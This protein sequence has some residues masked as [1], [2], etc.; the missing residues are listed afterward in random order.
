MKEY[1]NDL[2]G[3]RLNSL[4]GLNSEDGHHIRYSSYK[5]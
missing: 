1:C 3:D 5:I 4:K 2:S